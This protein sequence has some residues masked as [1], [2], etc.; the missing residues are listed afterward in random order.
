MEDICGILQNVTCFLLDKECMSLFSALKTSLIHKLIELY[1]MKQLVH[2]II[3]LRF[4][5]QMV[6]DAGGRKYIALN[7]LHTNENISGKC[8]CGNFIDVAFF[9][10]SGECLFTCRPTLFFTCSECFRNASWVYFFSNVAYIFNP[11]VTTRSDGHW[12]CFSPFKK[13][14]RHKLAN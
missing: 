11:I 8:A 4:M 9:C 13:Q 3:S 2:R 1:K 5:R 10:I 6:R 7:D 12:Y 14:N